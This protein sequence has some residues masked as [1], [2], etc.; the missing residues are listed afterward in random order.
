MFKNKRSLEQ[1]HLYMGV[2]AYP[3][4][5]AARFQSYVLNTVLGGGM[6]SRLFQNIREKQGLAYSVYSE[7]AMYSDAG[8]MT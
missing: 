4:P 7:L 8:C 6:S 5:H 1:V 2:P 3:L